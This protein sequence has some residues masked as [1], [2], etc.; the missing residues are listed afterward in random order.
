[1]SKR[2][3]WL[4]N[5]PAYLIPFVKSLEDENYLVTVVES[6]T[7]AE[8][9]L[10]QAQFDL[11]I[12]D[13]MIPTLSSNEEQRYQPEKTDQGY[14]TGLV[15]FQQNQAALQKA[16][17]RVMVMTVRLDKAIRDEFIKAG[18]PS[19]AFATKYQMSD[20]TNFLDKIR[21]ALENQKSIAAPAEPGSS[22]SR[23]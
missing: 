13:V 3:L 22:S 7:E 16:G 5:D 9:C 19:D 21:S 20:P 1:M 11:M 10:Q 4:D 14:K 23:N 2:I 18:L 8:R 6:V 12:I 15:F 17:T